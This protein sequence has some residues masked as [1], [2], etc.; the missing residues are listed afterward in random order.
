MV[1]VSWVHGDRI[2]KGYKFSKKLFLFSKL[3][4]EKRKCKKYFFYFYKSLEIPRVYRDIENI[5]TILDDGDFASVWPRTA[6]HEM[7]PMDE[8]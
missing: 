1:R 7:R 4:L 2:F 6:I 8:Y 3:F 5:K